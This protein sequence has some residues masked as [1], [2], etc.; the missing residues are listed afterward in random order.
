MAM[1]EIT[2]EVRL[3]L[4]LDFQQICQL[5]GQIEDLGA[6]MPGR[7]G[8]GVPLR[9]ILAAAE[10]GEAATH[11]TLESTDGSFSASAALKDLGNGVIAYRLGEDPL[12][13]DLG[14]P[15]RFFVPEAGACHT[16]PVDACANVKYL[17]TIRVTTGPGRD[18]R[19]TNAAEHQDLHRRES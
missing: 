3:P 9:E 2:G 17:A 4:R 5:S 18:T 15:F 14:G 7:K 16:G 1:L 10:L 6:L 11:V 19:P 13:R 8:I 12:P